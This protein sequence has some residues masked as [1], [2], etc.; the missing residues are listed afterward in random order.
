[1]SSIE[2]QVRRLPL[3]R[4]PAQERAIRT[5]EQEPETVL[6]ASGVPCPA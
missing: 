1:M 6:A 2:I 3:M 5:W 4:S